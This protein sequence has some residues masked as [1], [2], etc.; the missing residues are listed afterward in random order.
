MVLVCGRRDPSAEDWTVW[1]EA[2]SNATVEYGVRKL[3]VVSAGGGPNARQRKQV[4]SAVLAKLGTAAEEIATAACG[5][6]AAVR[7]VTAAIGWLSGAQ[8]LKS[9]RSSERERALA[10]LDVPEELRPELL[11]AAKR[12][13]A[14]LAGVS[15]RVDRNP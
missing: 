1:S 4:V 14:E 12:F 15:A 9:F 8:R 11:R 3:F 7:I 2:Y 10:Y 13:E 5:D 6:S